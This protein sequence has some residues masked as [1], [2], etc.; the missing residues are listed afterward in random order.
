[1]DESGVDEWY[2]SAFVKATL[3]KDSGG[4]IHAFFHQYEGR[5][6]TMGR[7]PKKGAAPGEDAKAPS[8]PQAFFAV[9]WMPMKGKDDVQKKGRD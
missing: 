2:N 7:R 1:M 4:K 5:Q 9:R 3:P 8:K 6:A